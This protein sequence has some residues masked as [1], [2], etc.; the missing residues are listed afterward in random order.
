MLPCAQ[1]ALLPCVLV[2]PI[3]DPVCVLQHHPVKEI[4]ISPS[5]EDQ[6]IYFQT[7]SNLKAI[8]VTSL[9]LPRTAH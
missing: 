3:I 7:Q 8:V 2:S 4:I 1:C 9:S 6:N 5:G